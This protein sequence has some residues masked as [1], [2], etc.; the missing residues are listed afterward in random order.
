MKLI[1]PIARVCRHELPDRCGTIVEVEG[2]S[3]LVLVPLRKVRERKLSEIVSIGTQM[4]VDDIE[5]HA[6][7]EAVRTIDEPTQIIG[8]AVQVSW[9]EQIDA[10]IS[11]AEA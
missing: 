11:P 2:V 3:P 4:V 5:D 6:E 1:G 8:R 9:R 7:A 10:V